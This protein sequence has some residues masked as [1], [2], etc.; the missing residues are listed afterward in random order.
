MEQKITED[1]A[2]NEKMN[3]LIAISKYYGEISDMIQGGGGNT[4]FKSDSQMWVK[5]SGVI[6]KEINNKRGF[7]AVD[8]CKVNAVFE[9]AL[10]PNLP[11]SERDSEVEK[12]LLSAK[13]DDVPERPSIETFLHALLKETFVVHTHAIYVNAMACAVDGQELAASFFKDSEYIWI[14][15]KKPGYPLGYALYSAAAKHRKKYGKVPNIIFLENHGLIVSGNSVDSIHKTTEEVLSKM[16]EYFGEYTTKQ[17]PY[18]EQ[19]T[20]KKLWG[21]YSKAIAKL[22]PEPLELLWS[23]CP[24]VNVLA[25][26]EDFMNIAIKGALYP[27]HIV[28]C[29]QYPLILEKGE[30]DIEKKITSFINTLGYSPRYVVVPGAGVLIAGKSKKDIAIKEEMLKT[31]VKTM[32]LILRSRQPLFLDDNECKYLSCWEAEKYR[33]KLAG[34]NN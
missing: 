26:D 12:R 1:T 17:F 2:A 27:D 19:K 11:D 9:D 7:V 28:Y 15:Y 6:L 29:G 16:A 31:H 24:Y 8:L 18:Q 33:Q 14:P 30:K 4:S 25:H 10:L 5:A 23:T 22:S 3:E 34:M 20:C 32:T 21:N 13:K